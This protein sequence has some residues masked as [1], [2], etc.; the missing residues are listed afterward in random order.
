M[1][2]VKQELVSRP[3]L[4]VAA[5][6]EESMRAV[7]LERSFAG[8]RVAV[9][10][11]SRNIDRADELVAAVVRSLKGAGLDPAIVPAMGSHG[12]ATQQGQEELLDSLG[13][14][15]GTAGAPVLSS[16]ETE[17]IGTTESGAEVFFS[18]IA[19]GADGIVV[20]NRVGLH[21]GYSGPIQSGVVKML[22]VGLG[23]AEG[24]KALHEHGFG[25]GHLIGEAADVVLSKAPPVVAVAV[26][27]DGTRKLSELHVI[28]GDRVRESEPALLERAS[29]MWPRIPVHETDL[30]IVEELGKDISGVGMDPHI[31]GRGKDFP[32]G[33]APS[34]RASRLVALRLTPASG[35]NATG[36][37]HADI[38]TQAFVDATDKAV[39]YKNVITSGALYRARLPLVADTDKEAIEMALSS[40]SGLDPEKARV[41]RIRNTRHLEELDVSSSLLPLLNKADNVTVQPGSGRLS[42][43]P[44]GNL[45]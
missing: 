1:V 41:V 11:G 10:V 29:S 20:I 22:A 21:T 28:A 24:A 2:T 16:M 7:S 44:D 4:D 45:I 39:T 14:N 12:G 40:M 35:G 33:Q 43:D 34:F 5:A 9:A 15:A 23:K 31:T 25:S 30:L 27:E 17:R 13:I 36:I 8:P 38:T 3:I 37:G 26:L 42:F 6:V 32:R 18:S 19:L